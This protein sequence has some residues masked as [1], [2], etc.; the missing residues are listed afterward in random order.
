MPVKTK[1]GGIVPCSRWSDDRKSYAIIRPYNCK[2][3]EKD[4]DRSFEVP[5]RIRTDEQNHLKKSTADHN[6]E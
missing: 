4:C 2:T 3:A 1:A 6:F 5:H